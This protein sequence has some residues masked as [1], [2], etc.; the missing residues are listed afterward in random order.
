M[1]EPKKVCPYCQG[2]G[3]FD[4][5]VS[6]GR[7]CEKC[8]GTGFIEPNLPQ[9]LMNKPTSPIDTALI[10]VRDAIV[11]SNLGVQ[12]VI[13]TPDMDA[14]V[15]DVLE[16]LVEDTTNEAAEAVKPKLTANLE[17]LAG[18]EKAFWD[19]ANNKLTIY[20]DET[21]S[22]DV[23]NIRVQK[24]LAENSLRDSVSKITFISTEKDMFTTEAADRTPLEH[25]SYGYA[26]ANGMKG[27]NSL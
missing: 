27:S 3:W 1:P 26:L 9:P 8:G 18:I 4:S 5:S 20:Y 6:D 16:A 11:S 23:A 15:R 10:G 17:K 21:T 12:M 19:S 13:W 2:K 7:N 24:Y 22:K 14:A 25:E